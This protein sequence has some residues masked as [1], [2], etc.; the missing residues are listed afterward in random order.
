MS[1]EI[2]VI[3]PVYNAAP[4]LHRCLDSVCGQTMENIEIICVNDCSSDESNTL[5]EKYAA[6]DSRVLPISFGRNQGAALARNVGM[7]V[8]RG[9]WLSFVDSDDTIDKYFY[10]TLHSKIMQ[11]YVDIIEAPVCVIGNRN[12]KYPRPQWTWLWSSIFR[13]DFIKKNNISFPAHFSAEDM[14]FMVNVLLANP[15]RRKIEGIYYNYYQL[16]TSSS[17][18]RTDKKCAEQLSAFDLMFSEIAQKAFKQSIPPERAQNIFHVFFKWLLIN[19]AYKFTDS[20][21]RKASEMLVNLYANYPY[22]EE[23]NT[24]LA[25]SEPVLLALLR[26]GDVDKLTDFFLSG[27]QR[28][29][30]QLRARL[31][32][33][34]HLSNS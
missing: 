30:G 14:V 23:A 21:K 4:W 29:A 9:E 7:A 5:L 26:Q 27:K 33:R 28:L 12:V 13:T 15:I 11:G 17:H 31:N 18:H 25:K 24:W 8:A 10:A 20:A 32:A 34:I 2:S 3:I 1:P 19:I 22:F 6:R 16:S